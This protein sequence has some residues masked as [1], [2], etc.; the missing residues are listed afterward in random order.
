M[1]LE[2]PEKNW[3]AYFAEVLARE[4][5]EKQEAARRRAAARRPY[6]KPS[7]PLADY[8]GDY[9]H[10]AYGVCKVRQQGVDLVWEW[11]SFKE[12]LDHYDGDTFDIHEGLLGDSLAT[13]QI[14]GKKVSGLHVLD[15]DFKRR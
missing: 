6:T 2:L 13:F 9:E 14:T 10:P 15:L 5:R 12:R 7:L 4:A 3:N 11:S 1:L 8:A